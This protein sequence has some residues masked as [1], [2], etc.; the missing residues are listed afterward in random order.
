[1]SIVIF[2]EITTEEVL[3]ALEAEGQNYTG[4][5]VDMTDAPQRKF[6]KDAAANIKAMLK[7]LDSQRII[8]TRDYRNEVEK[9][10]AAIKQRL[11]DA[12]APFTLLID[13]YAA[14]CKKIRDDE[15]AIEDARSLAI[16]I[17]DNHEYALLMDAKVM[18]DKAE[19]EQAQK[20]RDELIATEA[21]S[22]AVAREKAA[23]AHRVATAKHEQELRES[24]VAH[25]AKVNNDILNVLLGIEGV[26]L[27]IG[28]AVVI[29]ACKNELPKVTI[30]Y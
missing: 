2:E 11:E 12:N 21:A 23:Q 28:K 13:S 3:Q 26:S 18:T 27:N 14:D 24:D 29:A 6:V 17:E 1:M 16:E 9:E 30:N 5:H 20:E 19:A 10:A 8:K 25:R 4:L 22:A 7:R 15:K